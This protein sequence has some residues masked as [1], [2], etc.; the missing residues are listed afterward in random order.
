M[1]CNSM[2]MHIVGLYTMGFYMHM[3]GHYEKNIISLRMYDH[4]KN[5]PCYQLHTFMLENPNIQ[6]YTR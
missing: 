5:Q 3:E 4:A 6:L 1:Q 2:C